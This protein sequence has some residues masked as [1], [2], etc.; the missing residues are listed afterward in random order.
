L[1]S[2][3]PATSAA[4]FKASGGGDDL[5]WRAST[6]WETQYNGMPGDGDGAAAKLSWRGQDPFAEPRLD[7]WREL[8]VTIFELV[9]NWFA[10]G[11][12]DGMGPRA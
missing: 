10:T 9:D 1:V 8:A 3:K 5:R 11:K 4:I 7:E 2:F 6:E 12:D